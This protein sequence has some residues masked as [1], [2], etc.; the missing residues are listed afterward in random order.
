[1]SRSGS[2]AGPRAA[3]GSAGTHGGER[4]AVA[5]RFDP[6]GPGLEERR[7]LVSPEHVAWLRYV[8]EAQDGLAFMHS[9][10]AGHVYVLA[11]V[12]RSAELDELVADLLREGCLSGVVT[13]EAPDS[14]GEPG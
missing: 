14:A 4:P 12:G 9:D 1:M 8:L 13:D 5:A 10:G 7:V 11:P 2:G 6:R 3:A